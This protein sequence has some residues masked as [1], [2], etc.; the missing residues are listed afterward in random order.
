MRYA[1]YLEKH[2][3]PPYAAEY[4]DY[5]GLRQM[6]KGSLTA[7]AEE[8][9]KRRFARS[10]EKV[11]AFTDARY[12]VLSRAVS[13]RSTKE[14]IRGLATFMRTNIIGF[15]KLLRRHDKTSGHSLLS[16]YR[17]PLREHILETKAVDALIACCP[18][19][20]ADTRPSHRER[21]W[22]RE[23]DAVFVKMGLSRQMRGDDPSLASKE[24]TASTVVLDSG[25]LRGY[26][27]ALAGKEVPTVRVC[28]EDDSAVVSVE[29]RLGS[30]VRRFS[31]YA[32]DVLRLLRGE[33]VIEAATRL[34]RDQPGLSGLI[35]ETQQTVARE[36]LRPVVRVV[37]RRAVFKS[38]ETVAVIESHIA[39]IREAPAGAGDPR[40]WCRA[41]L[42]TWPF[43]TVPASDITRFQ[44]ALLT[45]HGENSVFAQVA[46]D[47]GA[48]R[49][50]RFSK[51]L[52]A[53][54]SLVASSSTSPV[55]FWLSRL[56][57]ERTPEIFASAASTPA[58]ARQISIPVRVEPKV[59]FAN[60]RTFLSWVQFAI[61]LGGIGTA[62]IGLG[63]SHA[64]ACG[65]LLISV[66]AIFA[67]YSLYLFHWRASRIRAK[68]P[69]PY[70]DKY[71][72]TILVCVFLLAI[73][74]S[75]IFKLPMKHGY[76]LNGTDEE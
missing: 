39:M 40:R 16:R 28:W 53:I 59:F 54:A 5:R 10:F 4:L 43:S 69:G 57:T 29:N 70:D 3:Y 72:P 27:A 36:G 20:E 32:E 24:T 34:N 62:M 42:G 13:S 12:K 68:D 44:R 1:K 21:Y 51:G 23:E 38:R 17:A 64:S 14:E 25:D 19:K 9:F 47:V 48:E 8:C 46:A 15:K 33:D 55:P 30:A 63:N 61:F 26:A 50:D 67:I 75:F 35:K 11:F 37:C 45:L 73:I 18:S 56:P 41:D 65:I 71:G 6:L 49:V 58:N 66:A 52:H 60:E 74:L 76:R 2:R 7:E 22:I 31:L